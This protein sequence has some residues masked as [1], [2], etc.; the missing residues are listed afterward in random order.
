MK[1]KFISHCQNGPRSNVAKMSFN[2]CPNFSP[3]WT[4]FVAIC[5][6][7]RKSRQLHPKNRLY[8]I[9]ILS[10][11]RQIPYCYLCLNVWTTRTCRASRFCTSLQI[12]LSFLP[13]SNSCISASHTNGSHVWRDCQVNASLARIKQDEQGRFSSLKDLIGIIKISFLWLMWK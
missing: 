6:P 3:D 13:R 1:Q 8:E 4:L 9:P 7:T 11:I 12:A 5:V 10:L 2:L